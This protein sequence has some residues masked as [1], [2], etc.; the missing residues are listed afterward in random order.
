M[1]MSHK[2]KN[3]DIEIIEKESYGNCGIEKYSNRAK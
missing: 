3:E 2:I 1:T